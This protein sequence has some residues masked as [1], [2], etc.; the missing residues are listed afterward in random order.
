MHPLSRQRWPKSPRVRDLTED[1]GQEDDDDHM[2]LPGGGVVDDD[3]EGGGTGAK[4][5]EVP[6]LMGTVSETRYNVSVVLLCV[7]RRG[8]GC[9]IGLKTVVTSKTR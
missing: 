8:C 3:G 9:G 1:Y 6:F 5:N 7:P 4:E 2:V